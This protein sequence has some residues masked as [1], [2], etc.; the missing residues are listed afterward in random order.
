MIG[1]FS[2]RFRRRIY[3]NFG[4]SLLGFS[5][6]VVIGTLRYKLLE[7]DRYSALDALFMTVITVLTIG[8]EETIDLHNNPSGQIFTM[9]IAFAGVGVMTY[10]FST[11][12]AF[13]LES[14]LDV[15]LRRRRME[16]TIKKLSGHFIVCGFGHDT[17]ARRHLPRRDAARGEQAARRESGDPR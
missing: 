15:T 16:K 11:V 6:I 3:F 2:D 7:G 1:K 14:D 9:G 5:A 10:F 17:A 4:W 8:Y 13:I 12:T